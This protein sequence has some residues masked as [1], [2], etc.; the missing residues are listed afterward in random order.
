MGA[1]RGRERESLLKRRERE[2]LLKRGRDSR[3]RDCRAGATCN[4]TLC[5][6]VR[7]WRGGLLTSLATSASLLQAPSA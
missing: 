7:P 3:T 2:S 6:P 5:V 1:E 4:H